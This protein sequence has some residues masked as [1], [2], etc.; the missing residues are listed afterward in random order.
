MK[1]RLILIIHNVRSAHN[2]GAML[3]S[4]DGM[5][6]EKLYLTG[7]SPYPGSVDDRRMPHE[8]KKVTS[9]IHKTALGAEDF[10]VW[11]YEMSINRVVK[12][13]AKNGFEVAALEQTENARDLS[14]YTPPDKIAVIVG[15]EIGGID[16]DILANLTTHLKIPMLG[17]KESLN[18]AAAAGICL[19]HLRYAPF[20]K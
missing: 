19:Y 15:S 1:R 20:K 2:V 11:R 13:L 9:Q 8:I 12:E 5:G 7:Y 17:K 18:V 3:R 10:V 6:V 14:S 16:K 4:A